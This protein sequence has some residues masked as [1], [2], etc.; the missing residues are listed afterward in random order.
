[1]NRRK[2]IESKITPKKSNTAYLFAELQNTVHKYL[3][4]DKTND[5]FI[6]L[7]LASAISIDLDKPIW[8]MIEAPSSS[9]KTEI[10][11][12]LENEEKF[13]KVMTL[14]RKTLFS[15]HTD[16]KGG[17][18]P[19]KLGKKGIL[20]FPDFTT[21]IS[22]RS[23]DRSEVFN[24][25]RVAYDGE[26]GSATGVDIEKMVRWKGKLS[27]IA[28]VTGAIERYKEKASDLGER[29]LYLNHSVPR[30]NVN[31]K[32]NPNKKLL[33]KHAATI[34]HDLIKQAKNQ[35]NSI[36][37][38]DRDR[39]LINR[40]ANLIAKS[41]AVIERGGR[42]RAVQHVHAAEEPYRLI[43][44]LESLFLSMIAI[45][46]SGS[47]RPYQMLRNITT[48]S[49][50]EN[51]WKLMKQVFISGSQSVKSLAQKTTLVE[52]TGRRTAEDLE[53]L[54]IFVAL[55]T[56]GRNIPDEFMLKDDFRKEIR[57]IE[58]I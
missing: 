20:C 2:P 26:A 14:T 37:I 51:R 33:A 44:Q 11:T 43:E 42:D 39:I 4:L 45:H 38:S 40:L 35:V 22:L 16:A 50:P 53:K 52:V 27:C 49:I 9:G 34:A 57:E 41:R 23:D 28:C 30:F 18:I 8:A 56:P 31:F 15:G 29:F 55:E 46:G 13:E 7:V 36:S 1:M 3:R 19:Y 58:L 12:L 54:G 5:Y 32:A 10:L 21:V 24:Q 17:F 6:D 47:I 25:L 48:S